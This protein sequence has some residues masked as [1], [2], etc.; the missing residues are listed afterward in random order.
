MDFFFFF[1]P[2]CACGCGEDLGSGTQ[3]LTGEGAA[4]RC[5]QPREGAGSMKGSGTATGLM[6]EAAECPGQE[7][8]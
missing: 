1:R 7:S 5:A 3:E 6:P 4:R 2:V 8:G